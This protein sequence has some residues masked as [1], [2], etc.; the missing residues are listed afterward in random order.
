MQHTRT[1]QRRRAMAAAAKAAEAGPSTINNITNN[2]TNNN[3][4]SF[5]LPEGSEA[6]RRRIVGDIRGF[7]Q[8]RI[9]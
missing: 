8:E 9:S 1:V 6:K 2:I 3:N 5:V 7:F 4:I